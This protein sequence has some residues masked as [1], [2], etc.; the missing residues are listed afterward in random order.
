MST[1]VYLSAMPA[2]QLSSFTAADQDAMAQFQSALDACVHSWSNGDSIVL[3]QNN[4]QE[5]FGD[6]LM[7]YFKH[8]LSQQVGQPLAFTFASDSNGGQTVVQ[9]PKNNTSHLHYQAD[10]DIQKHETH[11]V[12]AESRNMPASIKK[13]PR[14]RN[15][16]IIFRDAMHKNL[17]AENPHLTVQQIST[18]CSQIW[19]G[20]SPAEKRPWQ[21]AA[22][23]AKEEHLRAHPDYKYSPRKPGEKKKRQSRKSKQAPTFLADPNLFNFLPVPDLTPPSLDDV[24]SI[25][26]AQLPPSSIYQSPIDFGAVFA[27]DVAHLIEPATLL[28]MEMDDLVTVDYLHDSESLR[29]D[30]LETEFG[31]DLEGTMPFD[32]FGEEAF[33]FRAGADGNATLPSIY[34][35]LY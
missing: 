23:S 20:L 4:I 21:A 17:K 15:C 35:D 22:K 32:L 26:L 29:H 27:A 7:Q 13:A 1:E 11:P 14:P 33:A 3:L 2:E 31:T 19:H 16:W 30:R 28:G 5:L 6:M 9:M 10:T 8:S 34:S 25:A 12:P 18:R 24:E